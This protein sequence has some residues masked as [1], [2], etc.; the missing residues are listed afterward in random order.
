MPDERIVQ[1]WRAGSW[2][3]GVYSIAEF[4]LMEQDSGTRLVFNHKGFPKDLGE[5]LASGWKMNYW[6]PLAKFL[7]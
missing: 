5:H 3:P 6:E 4:E 7:A 1:A 2:E